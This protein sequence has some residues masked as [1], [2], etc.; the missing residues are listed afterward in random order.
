MKR[1]IVIGLLIVAL[2]LV[3][4]GIGA[5]ALFTANKGFAGND[6]F[7]RRNISSQVEE[8]SAM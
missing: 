3:C 2:G 1:P 5:V 6:P 8:M 4:L 7:D